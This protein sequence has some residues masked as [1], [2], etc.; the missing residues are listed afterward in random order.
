MTSLYGHSFFFYLKN[1]IPISTKYLI[2]FLIVLGM[3]FTSCSKDEEDTNTDDPSGLQVEILSI[4]HET[5][6]V[7]IQATAQNANLYQLFIEPS[8]VPEIVNNTG[9]FEYTFESQGTH[10]FS[11]RAYGASG[12]YVKV[13]TEVIIAVE[14]ES[15]PLNRGY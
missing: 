2:S 3:M 1:M 7:E 14:E 13:T 15:I 9:Y 5:G 6:Y 10:E 11:V 8:D 12:K 4:D